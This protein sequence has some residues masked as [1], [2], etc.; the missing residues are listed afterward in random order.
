[1]SDAL[2]Y[3]TLNRIISQFS[4]IVKKSE[5][6][7]LELELGMFHPDTTDINGACVTSEC[8]GVA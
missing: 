2:C 1:M 6:K 3:R 8:G 7:T 5:G 4:L